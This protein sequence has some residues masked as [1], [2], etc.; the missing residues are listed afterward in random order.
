MIDCAL[1]VIA[2]GSNITTSGTSART[3]IPNAAS[4]SAPFYVR[5]ACTVAAYV[6]LGDSSVVAAA[7]DTLLA[8]GESLVLKVCGATH[9][10]AIQQASAGV[11]NVVPL[12][13]V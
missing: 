1:S 6:R 11:V 12:E 8:P 3:T 10:A 13:D 9:I 5:V 2:T 4:G 7:G